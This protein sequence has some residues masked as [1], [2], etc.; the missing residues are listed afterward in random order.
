MISINTAVVSALMRLRR[1]SPDMLA[2]CLQV[3]VDAFSS[4]LKGEHT[5]DTLTSD[6]QMQALRILGVSGDALRPDVIHYW[7]VKESI[8]ADYDALIKIVSAFGSADVIHLE[9]AEAE[10]FSLDTSSRFLMKFNKFTAII[11]LEG[12]LFQ[13]HKFHLK[14]GDTV[15]WL[16]ESTATCVIAKDQYSDIVS[17]KMKSN[18]VPLIEKSLKSRE[19]ANKLAGLANTSSMET[20]DAIVAL[21]KQVVDISASLQDKSKE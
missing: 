19:I 6:E 12:S 17:K 4:W 21:L 2:S 5:S 8:D 3:S 20:P 9:N 13:S 1:L 7:T 15:N 18:S 16:S 10:A 14:L 11:T